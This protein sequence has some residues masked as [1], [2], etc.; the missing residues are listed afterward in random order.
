MPLVLYDTLRR[1]EVAF[2]PRTPGEAGL[3]VC[4]PTVQSD[5]HV[6]HGR[7]AVVFDVLRRHLTA[8]GLAVRFVQNVTDVD[9]KIILR[10]R[11]ERTDAAAIATRYTRAW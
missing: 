3:Y 6:G 5:A 7:A 10:A 9:D 1:D 8:S 2:E 4:G 11:R